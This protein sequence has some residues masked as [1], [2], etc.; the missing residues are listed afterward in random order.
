MQ[1]DITGWVYIYNGP[2][3]NHR[4]ETVNTPTQSVSFSLSIIV[5]HITVLSVHPQ[6]FPEA[7]RG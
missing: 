4:L 3:Q 5:D 6:V 2:E 7:D 1:V